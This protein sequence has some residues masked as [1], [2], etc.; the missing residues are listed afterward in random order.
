MVHKMNIQ[1]IKS[2]R[3]TIAI[4]I[5]PDLQVIVRAPLR[6][7]S[8]E[9]QDFINQKS[10]W[11]SKN[12][13]VMKARNAAKSQQ[14][15]PSFTDEEIGKLTAQAKA[16]L[17]HRVEH[18]AKIM[19]VKYG[20][21]T[22]RHQVSRWGSCSSKSN[23]NFNCL[24]MLCPENVRDYVIIHELCHLKELNHSPKF[25]AEVE[26][27]CPDY[28]ACKQWLKNNGSEFIERIKE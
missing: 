1:I 25:W 28:R 24:L 2:N 10:E 14:K 27:Y 3:K 16:Y 22:V 5:K 12:L 20:R 18:F 13:E 17:P 7:N 9:I 26:K 11:I 23:L 6:M 15:L 19:G 8:K 21:I 4:E